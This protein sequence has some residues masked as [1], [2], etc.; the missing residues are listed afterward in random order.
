M[1]WLQNPYKI[2]E[3]NLNNNEVRKHFRNKKED[4]LNDEMDELVRKNKNRNRKKL[5]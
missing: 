1:Q 3:D 5:I 2:N 4:Y